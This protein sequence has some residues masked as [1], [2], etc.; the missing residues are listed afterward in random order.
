MVFEGDEEEGKEDG[1][2]VPVGNCGS[3]GSCGLGEDRR[4]LSLVVSRRGQVKGVGA[5]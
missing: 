4:W 5:K 1:G 3:V 2:N